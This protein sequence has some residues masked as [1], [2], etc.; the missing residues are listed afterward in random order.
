MELVHL[1]GFTVA[2][3]HDVRPYERQT[4]DSLKCQLLT[5]INAPV[6]LQ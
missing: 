2:M 5:G 4:D 3:Y 6:G 1:V